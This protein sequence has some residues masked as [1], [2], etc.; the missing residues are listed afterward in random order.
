MKEFWKSVNIRW[1]YR[2]EFGVFFLESRCI[3]RGLSSYS[4]ADLSTYAAKITQL[5]SRTWHFR[6]SQ[7]AVNFLTSLFA[8][9]FNLIFFS[10]GNID[11]ETIWPTLYCSW[12]AGAGCRS[13]VKVLIRCIVKPSAI[14]WND[15]SVAWPGWGVYCLSV[16][17]NVVLKHISQLR[18]DYDTTTTRLRRKND[19]F[20]F[21]SRR[22]ASNGSRRAR[23]VV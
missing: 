17:W 10:T 19:M 12:N 14:I 13:H 15:P 22:I 16:H 5:A 23:Y 8:S 3:V 18:F 2:Q 4:V 6:A 20:V 11:I 7:H 1:S 9:Y 21:C